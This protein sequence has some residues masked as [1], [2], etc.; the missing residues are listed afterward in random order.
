MATPPFEMFYFNRLVVDEFTYYKGQ[1]HAGITSQKS[2]SRWVLSGTPPLD[3]FTDVKTIADFLN[4][5]LGIDDDS[6]GKEGNKKKIRKDM[7]SKWSPF[8]PIQ[9]CINVV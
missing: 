5:H 8:D 1:I 7:T 3:D 4:I 6:V 9:C 2:M